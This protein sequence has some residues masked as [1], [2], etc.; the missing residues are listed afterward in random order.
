MNDF[1]E[2]R[3]WRCDSLF[4]SLVFQRKWNVGKVWTWKKNVENESRLKQL[5]EA[6]D[7]DLFF[8]RH[9]SLRSV[10]TDGASSYLLLL[11]NLSLD[12][13]NTTF[14]YNRTKFIRD[15]DWTLA[16]SSE[17]IIFVPLLTTFDVSNVQ[18]TVHWLEITWN[19]LES[20]KK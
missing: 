19:W 20:K 9:S 7:F 3:S 11:F 18:L 13:C 15:L 10:R 6:I 2:S 1:G 8:S 16:K 17:L 4:P 12:I 5:F 14:T